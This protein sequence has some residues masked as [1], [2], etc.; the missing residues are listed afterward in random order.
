MR[1]TTEAV[2]LELAP[3]HSTTEASIEAQVS[4]NYYDG[5]QNIGE[6][7]SLSSEA[8]DEHAFN[9]P[10][11]SA[12][13]STAESE[14]WYA[15]VTDNDDDD[16]IMNYVLEELTTACDGEHL[17][18]AEDVHEPADYVQTMSEHDFMAEKCRTL[19]APHG[20]FMKI[21]VNGKSGIMTYWITKN[22]INLVGNTNLTQLHFFC[23]NEKELKIL[24]VEADKMAMEN[25]RNIIDRKLLALNSTIEHEEIENNANS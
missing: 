8:T 4:S 13:G 2:V 18:A 21:T 24:S 22:D 5:K 3:K 17:F 1:D 19:L 14:G 7:E 25:R 11:L 6:S 16:D 15:D 9:P 10:I 12:V 20:L 23:E